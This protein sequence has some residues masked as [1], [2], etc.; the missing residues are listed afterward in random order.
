M[1][2]FNDGILSQVENLNP[3]DYAIY[4]IEDD[5][6]IMMAFSNGL[7]GLSGLTKDEYVELTKENAVAIV[8][9]ADR[10]QVGETIGEIIRNQDKPAAFSVT[11]RIFHKQFGFVWVRAKAKIIGSRGGNPVVIVSFATMAAEAHE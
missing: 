5:R 10:K 9:D 3:G 6:L 2:E 1:E 4:C 7:P 8:L 11:Y